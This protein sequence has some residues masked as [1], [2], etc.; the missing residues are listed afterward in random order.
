MNKTTG[1]SSEDAKYYGGGYLQIKLLHGV[2]L[3][4]DVRNL[5]DITIVDLPMLLQGVLF[6][7]TN[8]TGR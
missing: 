8:I 3:Q 7:I 6:K 1:G 5:N 2:P 4:C